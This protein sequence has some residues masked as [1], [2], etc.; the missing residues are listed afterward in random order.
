MNE[1]TQEQPE[2]SSSLRLYQHLLLHS[3]YDLPRQLHAVLDRLFFEIC[4]MISNRGSN[5]AVPE[6]ILSRLEQIAA[7]F[8]GYTA[9]TASIRL[10]VQSYQGAFIRDFVSFIPNSYITINSAGNGHC[11]RDAIPSPS[12]PQSLGQLCTR[13]QNWCAYLEE[14][15]K[16]TTTRRAFFTSTTQFMAKQFWRA[17]GS[18]QFP[19][20]TYL[21]AMQSKRMIMQIIPTEKDLYQSD[22]GMRSFYLVDQ[23]GLK[24]LFTLH[25]CQPFDLCSLLSVTTMHSILTQLLQEPSSSS[26]SS[27]L[28][29]LPSVPSSVTASTKRQDVISPVRLQSCLPTL[30]PVS[31][32]AVLVPEKESERSLRSVVEEIMGDQGQRLSTELSR[33]VKESSSRFDVLTRMSQI[34]GM[35]LIRRYA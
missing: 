14:T 19:D 2:L 12:F 17:C 16:E 27:S 35:E 21:T 30:T 13:V 24:S 5:Q 29:E 22:H 15:V 10:F 31:A 7:Y 34:H 32:W 20:Q 3:S 9:P 33:A 6:S 8:F 25:V 23:R 28:P 1:F 26:S 4:D 18:I 11:H